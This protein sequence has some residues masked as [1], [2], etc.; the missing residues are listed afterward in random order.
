MERGK[1]KRVIN[2]ARLRERVEDNR[3]SP[4]FGDII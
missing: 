4:L 2:K 3:K 1:R